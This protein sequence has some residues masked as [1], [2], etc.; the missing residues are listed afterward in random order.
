MQLVSHSIESPHD[1]LKCSNSYRHCEVQCCT[2]IFSSVVTSDGI[3]GCHNWRT[4]GEHCNGR[5][6]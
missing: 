6:Y 2:D 4:S 3:V 1:L 5:Y